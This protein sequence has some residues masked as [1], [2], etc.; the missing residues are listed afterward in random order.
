MT[1][2]PWKS[3]IPMEGYQECAVLDVQEVGRKGL[4]RYILKKSQA[5]AG[6]TL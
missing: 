3:E 5:S 2:I 1:N 4:H 6:H